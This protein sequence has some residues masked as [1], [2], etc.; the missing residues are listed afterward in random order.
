MKERIESVKDSPE[1]ARA[2]RTAALLATLILLVLM[3]IGRLTIRTP[4]VPELMADRIFALVPISLVELGVQTVGIYAKKMAFV[5]C[6]LLFV[7]VGTLVGSLAFRVMKDLPERPVQ[8]G[9]FLFAVACWYV[10][11]SVVTPSFALSVFTGVP[12]P[13]AIAAMVLMAMYIVYG[14]SLGPLFVG[15]GGREDQHFLKTL[16]GRRAMLTT[17][18]LVAAASF[19]YTFLGKLSKEIRRGT[20]GRASTGDGVFPNLEGLALEVTPT[21][22]FYHVSKNIVDPEINVE[23]W[24]LEIR[25]MVDRPMRLTYTDLKGMDALEQYATLMCISNP[26]GGDLI[27]SAKW[28]GVKLRSLLERVGIQPSTRDVVLRAADGYSDSI[29]LERAL[30]EGTLLCYEMNG[31]PLT[32]THGFPARLLVP[33]IYGMKNV[34]WI[35]QIELVGY[36]YKGYWQARGWD[37]RAEYKTMSRID[38]PSASTSAAR[39]AM[40]GIAFAGDRGISKVEVSKDG[41]GTWELAEVKRPLSPYSWVLWHHPWLPD[42]AGKYELLVRATDGRGESQTAIRA[43]PIPDGASGYHTRVIKVV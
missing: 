31:A 35:T 5:G 8:F 43:E 7:A 10:S 29:L 17:L 40:A 33:G 15:L 22:D 1:L 37:D 39:A 2:Q 32:P 25:G 23:D 19:V 34:K 36:D 20:P 24:S 21:A 13:M 18:G 3:F 38:L 41:G 4:I 6:V 16:A 30:Q 27:G 14:L 42:H 26:V 11:L 9:I 28:K 12:Y